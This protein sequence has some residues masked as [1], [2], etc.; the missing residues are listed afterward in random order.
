MISIKIMAMPVILWVSEFTFILKI[1]R[2]VKTPW[3]EYG[4]QLYGA[5]ND[6][7]P[8]MIPRAEMIPKLNR[9]W[10]LM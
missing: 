4:V 3:Q 2:Y 6:P 8:Q 9:K 5:A 10:S 7:R 1:E